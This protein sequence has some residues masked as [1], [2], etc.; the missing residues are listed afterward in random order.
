MMK[1][2]MDNNSVAAVHQHSDTLVFI[3]PTIQV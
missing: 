3:D 1:R 2:D